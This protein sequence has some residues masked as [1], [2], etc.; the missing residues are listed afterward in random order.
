MVGNIGM[1]L[2]KML[3]DLDSHA[4]QC[5]LGSNT[6]VVYN[7]KKP[8]N[9]VGYNP[10][11]PV[12][13]DHHMIMRTLACDWPNTGETFILIVNQVIRNPKLTHNLLSQIQMWLNDMEV[14]DKPNFLT[15]KPTEHDHAICVVN[16]KTNEEL[17]IPLMIRGVMSTF[18]TRK[19]T[20]DEY[21]TCTKFEL[22]YDSPE[23]EPTDDWYGTM[24]D[25]ALALINCLQE[26]GDRT[27]TQYVSSVFHSLS[28]A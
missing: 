11:G 8:V 7:Y 28:T 19:P 17:V 25:Q 1:M 15:D 10:N 9:I 5:V 21:N 24:E 26:T 2:A 27:H 22:T 13:R 18:P 6:L 14:D 23:Y 3:T 4:N 12:S 20:Q 16:H